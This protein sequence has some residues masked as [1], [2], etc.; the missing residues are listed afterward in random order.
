MAEPPV[1]DELGRLARTMN[2][3]LER[4]QRS[5]ERQRRFVS[6]ASHELRSP[7][8]TIRT[9]I[10][11]GLAHPDRT[12]VGDKP[13]VIELTN[14]GLQLHVECFYLWDAERD[15]RA[16]EGGVEFGVRSWALASGK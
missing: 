6:D 16:G 3:M 2:T 7:L 10:E 15:A 8:A 13:A 5:H 9:S 1:A 4:L 14:Q 11:V 12:L